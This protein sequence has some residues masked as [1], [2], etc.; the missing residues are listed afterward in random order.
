MNHKNLLLRTLVLAACTV[1]VTVGAVGSAG[2]TQTTPA[3]VNE[4]Q[5]AAQAPPAAVNETHL[6]VTAVTAPTAPRSLT[7]T[8]RT[9]RVKLTWLAPSSNGGAAINKY[10]VQRARH[11]GG[12]WRTIARPTTRRFTATGL[13]NGTRYYFRV[14]AHNTAGSGPYS[15]VVSAVPRTVPTA[16]RSPVAT[17]GN[18]TVK[19]TWAR[20]SS[21]GGAAINKYAVQRYVPGTGWKSIAFPTKLSYVATSLVNGTKYSFRVRA[22]NAAGWSPASTVVS[23]VPRTVP[24]AP[25]PPTVTPA[26]GSVT[27]TW[28]SPSGNGAAVGYYQVQ[29]AVNPVSWT[30]FPAQLPAEFI[31]FNVINGG[32]Y[33][34]RVRAHNA[35]GWGPYSTVVIGVPRTWPSAPAS[36]SATGFQVSKKWVSFGFQAPLSDG[37]AAITSYVIQVFR[38]GVYQGTTGL[39]P[40]GP[41]PYSGVFQVL[42]SGNYDVE[43]SAENAAGLGPACHTTTSVP[44]P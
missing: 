7:A 18:A 40:S 26:D 17:P 32:T 9:A 16:P 41:P 37:G 21:N 5:L 19:L 35:A 39:S 6:A 30:T 4:T 33:Y 42:Y 13:T 10:A 29:R 14:R 31:D 24:N 12:P 25:P 2:A 28:Q 1:G 38:N 8:P 36:C 20:P 15:T 43:I 23:A 27:L 44:V 11:S 22:H 34:Y 3:A